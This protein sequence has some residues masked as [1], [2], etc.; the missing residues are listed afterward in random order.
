[1]DGASHKHREAAD[2]RRDRTLERLGYRVLRVSN[3]CVER[4]IE[5]ALRLVREALRA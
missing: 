1:M 3:A 5:E 2:A 4:D